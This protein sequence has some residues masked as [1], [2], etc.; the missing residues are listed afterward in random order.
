VAIL[1]AERPVA[2][3]PALLEAAGIVP[4]GLLVLALKGGETTRAAFL[5]AFPATLAAGCSGPTTQDL[6]RLPFSYVPA[7]RRMPGAAERYASDQEHAAGDDCRDDQR[8][9]RTAERPPQSSDS[10]GAKMYAP[11]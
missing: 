2:C 6:A 7:M 9:A 8:R 4:G 11:V 1:V 5:P 10:R 3:V